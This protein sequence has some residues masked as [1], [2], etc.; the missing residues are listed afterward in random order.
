LNAIEKIL[1]APLAINL[2]SQIILIA[3][4]GPDFEEYI[5]IFL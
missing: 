2:L 4:D 1:P 5:D 3:A